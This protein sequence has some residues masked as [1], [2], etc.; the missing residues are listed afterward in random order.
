[1]W[2][3]SFYMNR[4]VTSFTETVCSEFTESSTIAAKIFFRN[5]FHAEHSCEC[6][7]WNVWM[8][9]I[10]FIQT[11]HCMHCV[12]KSTATNVLQMKCVNWL[13]WDHKPSTLLNKELDTFSEVSVGLK[14][15]LLW[16]MEDRL[17]FAPYVKS[18]SWQSFEDSIAFNNSL[19]KLLKVLCATS[20][21][22][23]MKD[24]L[25]NYFFWK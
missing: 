1:M 8:L 7:L 5:W 16:G 4:S 6:T 21:K 10:D 15:G 20:K 11:T 24:N 2:K 13:L 22:K 14:T 9:W 12:Y 25:L 19:L 23:T 17:C 18:K 3:T